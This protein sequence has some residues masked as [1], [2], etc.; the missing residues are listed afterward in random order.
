MALFDLSIPTVLRREGGFVNDPND[1]GGATN[2]GVSLRWLKAQGLFDELV[3]EEGDLTHDQ[4]MV[5]R[6]MTQ[7]DAMA[8]YR[9]Y[10]WDKYNYGAILP[11]MVAT[12]ILDMAVNL[13]APRAHRMVQDALQNVR[14]DGILGPVSMAL[15][16]GVNSLTLILDLQTLQAQFYRNLV[17]ANPARQK[18][19]VGWLNRAYDRN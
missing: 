2:Y 1:P 13:G 10:W 11:Q 15:I 12:K 14:I 7:S 9:Q 19:L 17:L 3:I 18:F 8:F 6:K 5:I 4:V 16:N